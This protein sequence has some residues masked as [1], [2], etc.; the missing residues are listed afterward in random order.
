MRYYFVLWDG[1]NIS[2]QPK[3]LKFDKR[4]QRFYFNRNKVSNNQF[5]LEFTQ[6]EVDNFPIEIKGAIQCGL[7]KKVEVVT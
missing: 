5:Q 4:S 6:T 2:N 1:C 7:I 3:Y